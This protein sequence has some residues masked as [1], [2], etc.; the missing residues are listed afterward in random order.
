MSEA[1]GLYEAQ[2]ARQLTF[3]DHLD[4]L[5]LEASQ[6]RT[7]LDIDSLKKRAEEDVMADMVRFE[8]TG[9][10]DNGMAH[11]YR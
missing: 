7:G 1:R 6:K 8:R 2:E 3:S 9:K 10:I 11:D 5:H 4:R